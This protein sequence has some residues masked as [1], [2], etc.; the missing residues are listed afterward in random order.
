[1]LVLI[2]PSASGKT[3]IARLLIE[4]HGFKKMVT[5]TTRPPRLHEVNGRDYH[6]LSKKEFL[7][8]E[9]LDFFLETSFYSGHYYGTAFKDAAHDKVLI[10][11]IRGARAL[12]E[13]LKDAIMI[14]FI[15][16]PE[17]IRHARMVARGDAKNDI[18][19]RLAF[20]RDYF[21]IEALPHVD[22]I[23][24]NSDADLL[25]LTEAICR[26]YQSVMRG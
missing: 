23:I 15:K 24:D 19:T 18:A 13:T 1:M 14:F 21:N 25:E 16:T 10:V 6:F 26:E 2:G 3:E 9:K 8:K 11:D 4:R 12:Y 7:V 22:R 17:S 20:D 5:Y